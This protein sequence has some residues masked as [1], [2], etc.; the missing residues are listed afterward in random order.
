MLHPRMKGPHLIFGSNDEQFFNL[1]IQYLIC[2]Y[3]AFTE[4]KSFHGISKLRH[5][6]PLK[7]ITHIYYN[8]IYPYILY[9]IVTWDNTKKT[10][11]HKIETKQNHV[12]RSMF[13]ATL[14]G[15]NTDS[16]LPLLTILE[17]LTVTN[18]C[19]QIYTCMAQ[20]YFARTLFFP[21]FQNHFFLVC[22]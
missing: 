18:A 8:L 20:R 12:I 3:K 16:A 17:M 15:K 7:H 2:M 19:S 9:A 5:Y 13:F 6:L 4:F 1:E 21:F 10:N 22:Q 14:S 11:L